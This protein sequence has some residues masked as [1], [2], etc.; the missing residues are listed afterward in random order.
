MKKIQ[1]R[2]QTARKEISIY[3]R[4]YNLH[5]NKNKKEK[6]EINNKEILFKPKINNNNYNLKRNTERFE[7][8][9][10]IYTTKSNERKKNIRTANIYQL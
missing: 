8:R 7:E 1:K 3:E 2:P 10:R 6:N 4:L 9:Q 5:K